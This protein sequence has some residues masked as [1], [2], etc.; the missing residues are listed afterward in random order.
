MKI[1]VLFACL[2]SRSLLTTRKKLKENV[3]K[4]NRMSF[5]KLR[6]SHP[7]VLQI[8]ARAVWI[9][10]SRWYSAGDDVSHYPLVAVGDSGPV[11]FTSVCSQYCLTSCPGHSCREAVILIWWSQPDKNG[12][13]SSQVAFHLVIALLDDWRIVRRAVVRSQT[14]SN[15]VY[16]KR[17]NAKSRCLR[18]H[19]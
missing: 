10:F 13:D 6:T 5:K 18:W 16:L 11:F 2:G 8:A 9:T 15:L 7:T 19:C 4:I 17:V 14:S 3:D 1:R 12:L